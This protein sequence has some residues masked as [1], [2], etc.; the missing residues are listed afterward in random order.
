MHCF[1]FDIETVPD[2]ESGRVLLGLDGLVWGENPS[3]GLFRDG[4]F[5]DPLLGIGV[6]FPAG[7]Q[8]TL[9]AAF[10]GA[11]LGSSSTK[12]VASLPTTT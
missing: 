12:R 5:L 1:T 8:A 9:T 6:T 3:R 10:A 7:W 11:A 4:R 2:V